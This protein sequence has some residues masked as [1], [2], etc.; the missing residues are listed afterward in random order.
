MFPILRWHTLPNNNMIIQ[1]SFLLY[2]ISYNLNE[3]C[4]G[5]YK[6]RDYQ[7]EDVLSF[8]SMCVLHGH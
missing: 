8:Y 3:Y 2:F 5:D 6:G 4:E 7:R 1:F